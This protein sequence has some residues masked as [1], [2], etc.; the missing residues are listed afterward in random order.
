MEVEVFRAIKARVESKNLGFNM[1]KIWNNQ[2]EKSKEKDENGSSLYAINYPALFV[3]FTAPYE[4]SQ[5]GDGFQIYDPLDIRIHIAHNQLDS[6]DGEME[7]NIDVFALKQ[8][9]FIAL[10][11][12]MPEGCV[13]F[14]RIA[15]EPDYDHPDLYHYVQ[16]FRTNFIENTSEM[17]IGGTSIDGEAVE[18]EVSGVYV[19]ADPNV[20]NKTQQEIIIQVEENYNTEDN[21]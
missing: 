17:P 6:M 5:L 14:C 21:G 7:Q 4:I 9:V 1:I 2:I 19:D 15:E 13:A 8:Q 11:T 20:A 3:E 18:L 10:Q 12:F 16:T